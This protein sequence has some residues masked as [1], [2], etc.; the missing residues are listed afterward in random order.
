[1]A[2]LLPALAFNGVVYAITFPV[3]ATVVLREIW[4][5]GWFVPQE[6]AA[7]EPPHP[8]GPSPSAPTRTQTIESRTV[9]RWSL[10]IV[11]AFVFAYG[12]MGVKVGVIGLAAVALLVWFWR[13]FGG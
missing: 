11:A 2:T 4:A 8:R 7:N 3:V 10:G 6:A 1:F 5:K 12:N 13:D 9:V